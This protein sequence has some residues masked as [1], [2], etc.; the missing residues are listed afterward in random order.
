MIRVALKND[1]PAKKVA[2]K[3]FERLFEIDYYSHLE[4]ANWEVE[5]WI[6]KRCKKA[7]KRG[8]VGD[9]AL[10][11]G[12][13]HGKAIDDAY[14]PDITLR[15]IN[16]KIGYG[17]F[18]NGPLMKWSFIGEYTGLLRRRNLFFPNVN[19]YCFMY[20]REWI[21]YKAFTIDSQQQG[22]FTR[23]INHS[24]S[25]NLE[26]VAIFHGGIFHIIVRTIRDISAE[27]ELTYDYGD[28][29][30][31]RRRKITSSNSDPSPDSLQ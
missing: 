23:F 22:N 28:I 30:W 18:A 13:L 9:L 3:E 15:W 24:D 1:G 19:D 8:K 20:P 7:L 2:L 10:W 17:I 31:Q 25:P 21:A 29:Y 6:K 14:V 26:S 16:E 4:F 11:L 27:E 12:K 5:Q